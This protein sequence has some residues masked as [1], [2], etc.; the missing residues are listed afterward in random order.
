S[1]AMDRP[2]IH[3]NCAST[4]DGRI[5]KPDGSR[6]R[7]SERWD[8]ERVHRLRAELGCILVG[9]RTVLSDDPKLTVKGEFVKD[10]PALTKIII[11]GAGMVPLS[12]R[13]FRTPGRT[14]I[15]TSSGCDQDWYEGM[16]DLSESEG[17]DM[18]VL[19]L[20]G[21]GSRLDVPDILPK[22]LEKNV[23]HIL[24]EGGSET[25]WSFFE[26]G[27]F[28]RFTIYFGPMILGGKGPSIMGGPGTNGEPPRVVIEECRKTPAG[29]LLLEIGRGQGGQ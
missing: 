12:A 11:D 21:R 8:M 2:Y 20:E 13:A 29:G 3:I 14:V 6:L 23:T 28:D 17:V 16:M 19:K 25:I 1:R 4:L 5:A 7:I 10:P 27:L 22:L 9:A 18:E 24:V 26:K 15:V